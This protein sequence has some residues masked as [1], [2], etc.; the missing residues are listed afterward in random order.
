M[1]S[2]SVPATLPS[3][4]AISRKVARSSRRVYQQTTSLATY[5]GTVEDLEQ[6][7]VVVGADPLRLD[8]PA[9]A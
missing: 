7:L 4:G 6:Q 9:P 8:R 5:S 3:T 2:G 1:R